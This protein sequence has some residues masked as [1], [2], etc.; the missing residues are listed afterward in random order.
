MQGIDERLCQIW[1]L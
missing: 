1:C